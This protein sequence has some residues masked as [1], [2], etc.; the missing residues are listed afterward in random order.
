VSIHILDDD[1]LLNI[2]YLYRPAV[3]FD[4]KENQEENDS[5]NDHDDHDSE[6]GDRN[7]RRARV[8]EVPERWWYKL[9][10]VCQRWRR[11]I[12]GSASYLQLYLVCTYGTPVADMLAHSPPLPLIIDFFR[13]REITTEDEEGILLALEQRDRVRC[14]R[15]LITDPNLGNLIMTIDEEYPILEYLIITLWVQTL[16]GDMDLMLPAILQAPHLRH[17][18]LKGFVL[19]IGSRLLATAVGLVTLTFYMEYP[20]AYFEPDTL[21]QRISFMPQLETLHVVLPHH[22]VERQLVHTPIMTRRVTLPYLHRLV[23]EGVSNYIEAI[24]CQIST[25]LLEALDIR[26][27]PQ[28]TFF[29]PGLVQFVNTTENLKFDCAKLKFSGGGVSV[30][31]YPHTE[32]KTHS[33]FIYVDG[34]NIGWQ[35]SSMAQIFNSPYQIFSTVKH[36]A[37]EH[38]VYRWSERWYNVVDRTRWRELLRLFSNVKTL[39][40]DDEFVEELSHTLRPDDGELALEPLPG[41]QELTYYRKLRSGDTSDAFTSFIDARQNTGRPVTLVRSNPRCDPELWW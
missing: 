1:S 33:L 35:V 28:H 16:E 41:L 34:G 21:L 14:V 24:V 4:E 18:I 25:P 38:R 22:D 8:P 9:A 15:L 37:L 12:L 23:L 36:L 19:P 11:I 13:A 26:L 40:V 20:S 10:Q 2:F 29:V 7:Y 17:L 3:I 27:F 32:A 31:L 5:D 39:H 30:D 6:E